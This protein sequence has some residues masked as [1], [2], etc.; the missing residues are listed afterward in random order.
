MPAGPGAMGFVYFLGAKFLGYSA[1][2]RWVVA[3]RLLA[4]TGAEERDIGIPVSILAAPNDAANPST[5]SPGFLPSAVK[6]GVVRTLI[7]AAVGAMVGL[8]FWTIPYFSTHDNYGSV[9]FFVLLV[10]VRVG[11]WALL[12][13]WIYRIH[14]FADPGGMKLITFGILVSFALDAIGIVSTMIL[15]GGMWVC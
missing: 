4:R 6:A 7:G 8:G 14:P 10:P 3:P 1:F 11:E 9:V 12:Y 13:R 5:D 15:P 2:C